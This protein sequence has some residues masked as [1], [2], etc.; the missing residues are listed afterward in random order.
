MFI[1]DK[2]IYDTESIYHDDIGYVWYVRF[3][4]PEEKRDADF[5]KFCDKLRKQGAEQIGN[6]IRSLIGA[7]SNRY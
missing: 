5:K 7:K 3:D 1:N 2:G 6:Q 4:D